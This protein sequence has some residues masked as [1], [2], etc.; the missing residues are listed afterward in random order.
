MKRKHLAASLLLLA[1][2]AASAQLYVGAS[3]GGSR[4]DDDFACP[5]AA[6]KCDRNDTGARIYAGFRFRPEWALEVG[7]HDFGKRQVSDAATGHRIGKAE[8][9]GYH[10]VLA[11]HLSAGA[12]WYLNTRLG[13]ARNRVEV[14]GPGGAG[15]DRR[16]TAVYFGI[17]A[18][19]QMSRALALRL[20]L[21]TTQG[22]YAGDKG[23]A[24]LYTAGLELEF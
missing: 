7:A 15:D 8:L 19:Y 5:P 6:A 24:Y 23:R 14:E 12:P 17:G 22:E 20:D 1:T 4:F 13:V 3:A 18:A 10:L 21:D 2:G 11:S 9:R 16:K